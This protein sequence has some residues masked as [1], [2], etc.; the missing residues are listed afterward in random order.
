MAKKVG[1]STSWFL[2]R[3]LSLGLLLL[4]NILGER[5]LTRPFVGPLSQLAI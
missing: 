4:D 2:L 1:T 3:L 5:L